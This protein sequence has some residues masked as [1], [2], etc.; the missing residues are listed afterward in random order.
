M[1]LFSFS[2]HISLR[3]HLFLSI[4][5]SFDTRMSSYLAAPCFH[6][7]CLVIMLSTHRY[8]LSLLS[9]YYLSRNLLIAVLLFLLSCFSTARH[10]VVALC[11]YD[12]S[13]V[14]VLS[15]CPLSTYVSSVTLLRYPAFPF[16]PSVVVVVVVP[17]LPV[18]SLLSTIVLC[19]VSLYSCRPYPVYPYD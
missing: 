15:R 6:S 17:L 14:T 5:F 13:T 10:R 16:P 7:P 8:P 1:D 4:I 2:N 3:P 11:P 12:E 9:C 19:Q 18:P